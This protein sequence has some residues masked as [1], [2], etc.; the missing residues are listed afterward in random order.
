[1]VPLADVVRIAPV[2]ISEPPGSDQ[3]SISPPNITM[4]P[5]RGR[6]K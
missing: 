2:S 1:M 6:M 4:P 5:P 3:V